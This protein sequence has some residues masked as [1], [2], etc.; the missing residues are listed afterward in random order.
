QKEIS[1]SVFGGGNLYFKII[2]SERIKTDLDKIKNT[3]NG[4]NRRNLGENFVLHQKS[5]ILTKLTD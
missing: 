4:E 3:N 2:D 1:V 5:R